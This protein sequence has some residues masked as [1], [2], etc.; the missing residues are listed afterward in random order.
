LARRLAE[1]MGGALTV[2]PPPDGVGATLELRLPAG[3][4]QPEG[5]PT[6][7]VENA[8]RNGARS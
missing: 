6:T 7:T 8:L 5:P 1:L 4:R 3:E 2:T